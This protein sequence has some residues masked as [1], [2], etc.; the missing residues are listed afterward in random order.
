[1][2]CSSCNPI[3]LSENRLFSLFDYPSR[4]FTLEIHLLSLGQHWAYICHILKW[5]GGQSR[6]RRE[7]G[8]NE[9]YLVSEMNRFLWIHLLSVCCALNI[10]FC[11]FIGCVYVINFSHSIFSH[12]T[13]FKRMSMYYDM[14]MY[15]R[16]M[17][18]IHP[19]LTIINYDGISEDICVATH[20]AQWLRSWRRYEYVVLTYVENDLARAQIVKTLVG[21]TFVFRSCT[22]THTRT[23]SHTYM[24]VCERIWT[25]AAQ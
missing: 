7:Y 11:I 12:S 24:D 13:T 6:I 9:A 5:I 19:A 4:G 8:W 14:N 16:L 21:L 22:H 2:K 3:W 17:L 23:Q 25:W 20:T 10:F 15:T 18:T 1:M